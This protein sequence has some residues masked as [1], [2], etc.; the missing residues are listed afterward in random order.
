MLT[1]WYR[2]GWL[3]C[4]KRVEAR[5]DATLDYFSFG[6]LVRTF[7]APF[8]QISAGSVNGSLEV[9][10]RATLDRL[11]SRLIGTIVR[12]IMIIAGSIAM[13]LNVIAGIVF[14]VGWGFV[15]L[16]PIIGL[17]LF[18]VGWLPWSN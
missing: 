2:E 18:A 12:S 1:W 10:M 17:G 14:I 16:L 13:L 11:L 4:I 15:P 7:F 9:K 8:R 5:L 6:L 3:Q